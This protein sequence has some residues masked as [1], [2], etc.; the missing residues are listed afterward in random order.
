MA[1]ETEIGDY[2]SFLRELGATGTGYFL[3]GGQA[4]NF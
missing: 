2:L 3:E 1:C 4:V